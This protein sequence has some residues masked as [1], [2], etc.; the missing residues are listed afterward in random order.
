MRRKG[1]T[2]DLIA[3]AALDWLEARGGRPFFLYLLFTSP[4]AP[5]LDPDGFDPKLGT[6]PVRQG[7]RR[8]YAK[9]VERM[10]THFGEVLARLYAMGAAANTI[11]IFSSDNGADANGRNTPLRARKR[12]LWEGGIRVP[13]L[14]RW[15]GVLKPGDTPQVSLSMDLMP[16]LL[17]AAG[18][19]APAG[20]KLDGVDVLPLLTRRR[21]HFRRSVF[22]RSKRAAR[23]RKAVR[24]G[25]L[26]YV[27]DNGQEE[28]HDL[29]ADEREE[30]NLLP[31]A[32]S[33]AD[34]LKGLLAAWEKDV[35]APRL[36]PFR[37]APG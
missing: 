26:K 25:D 35:T 37:S 11:V 21:E 10:D 1:Y 23:L 24:D 20:R 32:K 19:S 22:W 7:D 14:I 2:T 3:Q 30:R 27:N 4:H 34:R 9:M 16:T 18:A 5:I 36:R 29:S 17:A 28:F 13:C 15:P 8:V 33:Q 6:A 31:G 12:T